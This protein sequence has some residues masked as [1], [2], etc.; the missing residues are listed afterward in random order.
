M[1]VDEA[2]WGL[3]RSAASNSDTCIIYSVQA[4]SL[5][6]R[7]P[8]LTLCPH[9]IPCVPVQSRLFLLQH[10]PAWITILNCSISSHGLY[11]AEGRDPACIILVSQE[12]RTHLPRVQWGLGRHLPDGSGWVWRQRHELQTPPCMCPFPRLLQLRLGASYE[13]KCC[14]HI[15]HTL[16]SLCLAVRTHTRRL[17]C[18]EP[19]KG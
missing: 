18:S 19:R 7:L 1:G 12:H 14:F 2:G 17:P 5:A 13:T 9:A 15:C 8:V 11:T 6:Q 4:S 16:T 3:W 10:R